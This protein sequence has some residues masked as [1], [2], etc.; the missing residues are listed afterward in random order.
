MRPLKKVVII[1]AS[2][3]G[4]KALSILSEY[5]YK[6]EITIIDKNKYSI[7]TPQI[8]DF[9]FKDA[10]KE[11]ILIET[12]PILRELNSAWENDEVVKI[13]KD[14]NVVFLNSG[15]EIHYDYLIIASGAKTLMPRIQG[16]EYA[17]CF[18]SFESAKKLKEKIREKAFKN[19][20]ISTL[21]T[22]YLNN[23]NE[24]TLFTFGEEEAVEFAFYMK[25][26]KKDC[27]ITLVS[28]NGTIIPSISAASAKEIEKDLKNDSIEIL[29]LNAI[30]TIENNAVT[31][32]D[33]TILNSDLTVVVAPLKA[34]DF[35]LHSDLGDKFGWLHTNEYMQLQKNIFAIGDINFDSFKTI[36]NA[37]NQAQIAAEKILELENMNAEVRK[38]EKDYLRILQTPDNAYFIYDS[39]EKDI[40]KKSVIYKELQVV[41]DKLLYKFPKLSLNLEEQL[42]DKLKAL[43]K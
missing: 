11:D 24:P 16:I 4:L 42:E 3:S 27:N 32:K 21:P 33:N 41:F 17:Y 19:V 20:V 40:I 10:K 39:L 18:N 43:L 14:K 13:D 12:P 36:Y 30:E 25:D 1:G 7:L 28:P 6:F 37:F 35:I 9:I 5:D 8:L 15:K 31:L 26:F 29:A 34:S 22:H 2:F 23:V 38:Y